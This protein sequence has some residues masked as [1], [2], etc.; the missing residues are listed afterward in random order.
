MKTLSTLTIIFILLGGQ[1]MRSDAAKQAAFERASA[2]CEGY[3]LTAVWLTETPPALEKKQPGQKKAVTAKVTGYCP[4]RKCCGKWAQGGRNRRTAGGRSINAP[5]GA[6][7]PKSVPFGTKIRMPDGTTLIADDTGGAMRQSEREGVLHIDRRF[8][9][10]RE[11]LN[12]GVR[13]LAV[14]IEGVK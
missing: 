10:H 14:T 9:T 13:T 8:S 3:E 11:A 6:A 12:C 2:T 1:K 4:C 7:V 5:N